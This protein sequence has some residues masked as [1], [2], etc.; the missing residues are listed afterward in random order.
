MQKPLVPDN[1]PARVKILR[2]LCILDT[3]LE[4]PYQELT[5]LA[6]DLFGVAVSLVTLVDEQ[7]QWFKANTGLDVS[8]TSRDVSFCAHA[9]VDG[10]PL[11]VEDALKDERFYDNPLVTGKP[12][13]RFY[14]GIPLTLDGEHL[15][16]TFCLIDTQPRRLNERDYKRLQALAKQAEALLRLHQARNE[17][18]QANAAKSEFLSSMS[19]ELRT[20]LNAIMG[21]S[22]LL[23]AS[24]AEPLSVKQSQQVEQIYRS[25]EHLLALINDVLDLAKVEAGEVSMQREQV[26]LATCIRQVIAL[27]KPMADKYKVSVI[28]DDLPSLTA[29]VDPLRLRQVLVNLISNAL[30]YNRPQ[31]SV[32]IEVEQGTELCIQVKDNGVGIAP[33]KQAEI[34]T[35]FNRGGFEQSAIE[36]SGVGL[37][38]SQN[39]V[40][41]MGGWLRVHS[42]PGNGSTFSLCLP[43]KVLVAPSTGS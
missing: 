34:F 35:A 25:G 37:A 43:A 4:S 22:Q 16:G 12:N 31:G 30:K 14:A 13:I 42:E 41:Q 23:Q 21:F 5:E 33:E 17:A 27:L 10:Q 20:P 11:L 6:C 1:E 15:L 28:A 32:W 39:L 26:E 38:V 40:E 3:S 7:R 9:I 2:D 18:Q 24:A 29:C 36:G 19:H 8:E